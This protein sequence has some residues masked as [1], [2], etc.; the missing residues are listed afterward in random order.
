[1]S[2]V[3]HRKD[4]FEQPMSDQ[5]HTNNQ[6]KLYSFSTGVEACFVTI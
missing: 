2:N 5:M 4:S 3:T 6:P 1:M